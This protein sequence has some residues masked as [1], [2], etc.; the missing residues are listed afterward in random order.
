MYQLEACIRRLERDEQD[1]KRQQQEVIQQVSSRYDI[2]MA[3]AARSR[4]EVLETLTAKV[5]IS[6]NDILSRKVATASMKENIS[7]V[8][9][10]SKSQGTLTGPDIVLMKNE[11][12]AALLSE[13]KIDECQE[14]GERKESLTFFT[15]E[16]ESSVLDL[17]VVRAYM[18]ELVEAAGGGGSGK[19][20]VSFRELTTLIS[21]LQAELN[22]LKG[23]LGPR[24]EYIYVHD[25]NY[26]SVQLY[27][28]NHICICLS[29]YMSITLS[30]CLSVYLSTYLSI[31]L[32][33]YLFIYLSMCMSVSVSVCNSPETNAK[34]AYNFRRE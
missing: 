11:V 18:G 13:E 21:D 34:G 24:H 1:L 25:Y 30:M 8:M 6:L 28:C 12:Q 15:C 29:V 16:A 10:R 26:I 20:G 2:L 4:E 14:L 19:V 27:V 33:I 7:S 31:Y 23:E 32:S 22:S 5:Q 17:S 3:W 9:A